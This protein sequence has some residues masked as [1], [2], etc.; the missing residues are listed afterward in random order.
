MQQQ[1]R[2]RQ[3]RWQQ[4]QPL[5]RRQ[6][7]QQQ[8]QQQQQRTAS[9][10]QWRGGSVKSPVPHV[11]RAQLLHSMGLP[12]WPET[13]LNRM[14]RLPGVRQQGG[15]EHAA[16]VAARLRGLG[17]VQQQLAGLVDG[18]PLL[19]TW[20]P[21]KAKACR[22]LQSSSASRLS[23]KGPARFS[24]LHAAVLGGCVGALPA[25]AAAGAPLDATQE[26]GRG[27]ASINKPFH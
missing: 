10:Q 11:D 16:A 20:A 8:Q 23:H 6:R 5:G 13:I 1:V 9:P 27:F 2:Q 26:A 21:T 12:G 25:L 4:Q 15:L 22:L 3:L 24:T 17:L 19:F 7:Q 18:C 14:L